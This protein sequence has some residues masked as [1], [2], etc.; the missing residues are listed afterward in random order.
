MAEGV[1]MSL[2]LSVLPEDFK[3]NLTT[4]NY[5]VCTEVLE[6]LFDIPQNII[7]AVRDLS[8]ELVVDDIIDIVEEEVRNSKTKSVPVAKQ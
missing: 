2:I 3:S 4:N 5:V 1:R 8:S 7:N 6:K